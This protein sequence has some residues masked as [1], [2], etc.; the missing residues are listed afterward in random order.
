MTVVAFMPRVVPA[1]L[2]NLASQSSVPLP[3]R[4]SSAL[5]RFPADTS[6]GTSSSQRTRPMAACIASFSSFPCKC[7]CKSPRPSPKPPYR[8]LLRQPSHMRQIAALHLRPP[9]QARHQRDVK[10][11]I[12]RQQPQVQLLTGQIA[13]WWLQAAAIRSAIRS[14][15]VRLPSR[16]RHALHSLN[17]KRKRKGRSRAARPCRPYRPPVN[18]VP[19]CHPQDRPSP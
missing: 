15:R 13:V 6:A 7:K 9:W 2:P 18:R 12:V 11:R 10:Q 5:F 14:T 1:I 19:P 17:C 3:T 4:L 16:R 8:S